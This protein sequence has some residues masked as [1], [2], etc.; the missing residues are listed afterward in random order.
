MSILAIVWPGST[1]AHRELALRAF[2][3]ALNYQI[4]QRRLTPAEFEHH[5]G[6]RPTPRARRQPR[7]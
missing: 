1:D 3:A 7:R 6:K 4:P 2:E 5:F